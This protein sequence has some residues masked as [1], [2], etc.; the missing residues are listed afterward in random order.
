ML[1]LEAAYY[2]R[3]LTSYLLHALH[4]DYVNMRGMAEKTPSSLFDTF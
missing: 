2:M 4:Q 3:F 1:P